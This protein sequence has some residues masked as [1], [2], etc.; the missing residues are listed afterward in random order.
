ML[1]GLVLGSLVEQYF[2]EGM[3]LGVGDPSYFLSTPTAVVLWV[4]V[5]AA[6]VAPFIIG[7]FRPKAR[8]VKE[9]LLEQEPALNK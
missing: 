3:A 7:I 5:A 8:S 1:I 4:I 6:V 2:L 9:T